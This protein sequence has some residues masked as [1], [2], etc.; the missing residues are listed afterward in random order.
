MALAV[1]GAMFIQAGGG[2]VPVAFNIGV[3]VIALGAF[4]SA[5]YIIIQ[6]GS[7]AR[8]PPVS[9]T[10]WEYW[11]GLGAMFLAAGAALGSC[12]A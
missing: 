5:V 2:S 10:S 4:T 7:L 12:S 1:A 11:I 8:Y 6:K 3:G 9:M